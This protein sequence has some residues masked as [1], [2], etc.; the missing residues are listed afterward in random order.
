MKLKLLT[1]LLV[2]V[3]LSICM[4]TNKTNNDLKINFDNIE[5]VKVIEN[6]RER[7]KRN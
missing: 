1:I 2:I 3:V 5:Q 4:I 6:N 7:S